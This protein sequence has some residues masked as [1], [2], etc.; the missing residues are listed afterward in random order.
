V[1]LKHIYFI[2]AVLGYYFTNTINFYH[3]NTLFVTYH[4]YG[5]MF[6]LVLIFYPLVAYLLPYVSADHSV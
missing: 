1:V 3:K 4:V 2:N 5:Y 6:T